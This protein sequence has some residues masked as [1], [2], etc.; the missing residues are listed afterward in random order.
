MCIRDRGRREKNPGSNWTEDRKKRHNEKIKEYWRK[1]K[2]QRERIEIGMWS[3]DARYNIK[4][5][6]NIFIKT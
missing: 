1:R 5:T 6:K 2:E 4:N 3:L